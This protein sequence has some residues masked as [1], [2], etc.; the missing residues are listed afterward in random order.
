VKNEAQQEEVNSEQAPD[1]KALQAQKNDDTQKALQTEKKDPPPKKELPFRVAS[2]GKR[3][4]ALVLDFVFILLVMNTIEQFSR[5]EHWDLISTAY[6]TADL[7]QFYGSIVAYLIFRDIIFGGRSLGKFLLGM[8]TH[9]IVD[10]SQPASAKAIVQR[11]LTLFIFPVDLFFLLK[12]P[13]ARRLGD[14]WCGTVV[15]DNP[16]ALRWIMRLLVANTVLFGFFMMAILLQ[17]QTIQKTSIYQT[18]LA[19]SKAH[20]PLQEA[21]QAGNELEQPEMSLDLRENSDPSM[22]RFTFNTTPKQQITVFLQLNPIEPKTWKVL[23]IKSEAMH[24]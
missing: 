7:V 6:T 10:L 13:Y 9:S 3:V 18:A 17:K 21:F 5:S 12:D 2:K 15:L 1:Q 4:F 20:P 19:A 16:N 11:N 23:E 22:V 8:K 24:D 14:Q